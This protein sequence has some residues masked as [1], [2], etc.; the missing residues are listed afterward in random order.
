MIV[1]W[2]NRVISCKKKNIHKKVVLLLYEIADL[3][4][5]RCIRQIN[6]QQKIV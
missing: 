5:F 6:T 3:W 2:N 1:E 4:K